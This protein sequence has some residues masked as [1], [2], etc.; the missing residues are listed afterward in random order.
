MIGIPFWEQKVGVADMVVHNP[1]PDFLG[2]LPTLV[3]LGVL[4]FLTLWG[5][6]K[7]IRA[8]RDWT[9]WPSN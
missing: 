5:L 9:K 8:V 3:G 6:A 2:W 1:P 7:V 4:I